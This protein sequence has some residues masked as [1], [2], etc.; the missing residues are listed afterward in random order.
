MKKK[1][2]PKNEIV[3]L[4]VLRPDTY[5]KQITLNANVLVYAF[6]RPFAV[7]DRIFRLKELSQAVRI[8]TVL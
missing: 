5:Q 2:G 7:M 3:P 4:D 8:G 6:V 1:K